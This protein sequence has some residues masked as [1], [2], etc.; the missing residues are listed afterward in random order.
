MKD[1]RGIVEIFRYI[2]QGE[3]AVHGARAEHALGTRDLRVEK[4]IPHALGVAVSGPDGAHYAG[5]QKFRLGRL[6]H[7][8]SGLRGE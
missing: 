4:F 7:M 8:V 2:I 1:Y 5:K 3:L 6:V